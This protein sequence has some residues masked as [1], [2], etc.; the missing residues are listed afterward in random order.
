LD[1]FFYFLSCI[2]TARKLQTEFDFQLIDSHFAYPDGFGAVLF[3]KYFRKPTTITLRGTLNSLIKIRSRRHLIKFALK[4]ANRIFSV[5]QALIDLAESLNIEESKFSAISNGVDCDRFSPVDKRE[6]RKALSLPQKGKIIIS[7]GAL[8]E[9]KG[10][11]RIISVLPELIRKY[12]DLLFLIVGGPSAEGDYTYHIEKLIKKLNIEAH[13]KLAGIVCQK[14]LN[15]WLSASDIFALATQYEGWANVF[16]E[17]MACGLPVVTSNVCGNPEVVK[18]DYC[19]MLFQF[20][21]RTQMIRCLEKALGTVW[22]RGRIIDYAQ[23]H[24]W[25]KVAQRIHGEFRAILGAQ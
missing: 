9:R 10:H 4:K 25:E 23:Q 12:P 19:G 17:A 5:S 2:P 3:G 11:H 14:N 8:V 21:N 1:G 6:A 16:L 15:L 24:S 18:Y 7:V 22:D 13:V 20:G